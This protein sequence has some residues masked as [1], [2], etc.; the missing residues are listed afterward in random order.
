MRGA[1]GSSAELIAASGVN[2]VEARTGTQAPGP[3]TGPA[4]ATA[5]YATGLSR[6]LTSLTHAVA[7][8]PLWA[9]FAFSFLN[10]VGTGVVT[11]GIYFVAKEGYGFSR[12]GN[13]ALGFAL[14]L[15]YIIGAAGAGAAVTRLQR[16]FPHLST[17]ALLA[18][19]VAMMAALCALPELAL[20]LSHSPIPHPW[21]IW[22]LVLLYSPLTGLLW[23]LTESFLS[24]GR[25]GP[26]LRSAV[27]RWNIV[28]S[29]ALILA[30]WGAAPFIG[31]RPATAILL[32]GAVHVIAAATLLWFKPEPGEHLPE[33]HEPHPPVY[34]R[35]LAT[36]RIL[37]PGSYVVLSTLGPALP[38][39]MGRFELNPGWQLR[40]AATW[41]VARVAT[42]LALE[43]W[44]GWHGR[45]LLPIVGAAF[46]L[47]GFALSVMAAHIDTG[48]TGLVLQLLGLTIFGIGMATIYTAAVYYAMEVGKAEVQAG[49]THEALIG[50]GYTAGPLCG[51]LASGA[52]QAGALP[53]TAFEPLLLGFVGFVALAVAAA[54]VR[55][56]LHSASESDPA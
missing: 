8:T 7:P 1:P 47:S 25:T 24:G 43:R 20:R 44:Q 48:R 21:A 32:L 34:A 45:W 13:Y 5:A 29:S 6:G 41:L 39:L 16:A 46:L 53:D 30:Y 10:S 36:I 11:N 56:A 9:V 55:R 51:L 52:V 37:L 19:V 3:S 17:R 27:G 18:V 40:L 38:L 28:W 23:P 12:L 42:F 50:V 4:P 35:L 22:T 2:E 54:S 14:G 33:H 26:I 15:T 49:G 31:H